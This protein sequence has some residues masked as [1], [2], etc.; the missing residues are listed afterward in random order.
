M[1]TFTRLTATDLPAWR[2][3]RPQ[4]LVL[5]AR[6][7]HRHAQGHLDGALRLDGRNHERLLLTE[8]KGRPVLVYCYH[9]NASQ[10]YAQMFADFG[11][12]DV[13]DLIGGWAAWELGAADRAAA[14]AAEPAADYPGRSAFAAPV[15]DE[16]AAWLA[17]E[18]FDPTD[19]DVPGAHGNTPLMFAAW[20]GLHHVIDQLLATGV[21]LDAVNGDGNNALWLAC[22]HGEPGLIRALVASGVPLDHQNSTGATALMY[23]ASA[24]KDEVVATLLALGA[25]PHLKSQDD[26]TAPDM[27]ATFDSLK[28]LR[29]AARR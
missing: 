4:A 2:A 6:D 28:L 10:T 8:P 16:L 9:G 23:A 27:C 5:D 24:G 29:A 20:R 15:P 1:K 18:G 26:F 13:A 7:S 14:P 22:V 25:D 11:F 21:R 19:P 3:A 12:T 17:A